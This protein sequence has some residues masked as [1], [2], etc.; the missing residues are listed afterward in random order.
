MN[1]KEYINESKKTLGNVDDN[2]VNRISDKS[3]INL[4]HGAIGISTES[5]EILDAFK[6]HIYY[7]KEL[8]IVNIKEEIGDVMWY[9][10]IFCR[11]L[12]IS[13]EEIMETNINKLKARYGEK[14]TEDKANNRNLKIEREILEN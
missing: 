9:C 3:H 8:D 1:T 14:F 12:N 13:F 6:K 5:G 10:A 4:L 7:G 2:M 11:D